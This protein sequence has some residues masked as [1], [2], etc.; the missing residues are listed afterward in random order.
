M[1]AFRWLSADGWSSAQ[2]TGLVVQDGVLTLAPGPAPG[3]GSGSGGF[4]RR[5]IA[6]LPAGFPARRRWT[7]PRHHRLAQRSSYGSPTP[8]SGGCWLR[9]WLLVADSGRCAQRSRTG[10]RR[11]RP[12]DR[13]HRGRAL[14][15]RSGRGPRRPGALLE[16][17]PLWVAVELGG[18]GTAHAAG[19]RTTGGDRRRRAG[20]RAAGRLPPHHCPGV[21]TGTRP[22]GAAGTGAAPARAVDDGDGVLGRYLGLLGA[23]LR[24]TASILG[25]LPGML[26]PAVAPDRADSPWLTRLATWVALDPALLPA[27]EAARRETVFTAA[28]RHGWRG[29]RRGSDRSGPARDRAH[30]GDRRAAG[31]RQWCGGWTARPAPARLGSPPDWSAPTPGRRCW[32]GPHGSAPA[33]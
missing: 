13:A 3:S 15:S 1:S 27:G 28:A 7:A 33:C 12:R 9:I 26:S 20:D 23:Q 29:T 21:A 16:D 24:Q 11:R 31:N 30:R 22:P 4:T 10:H 19:G 18:T 2:L 5:G 32:T 14:A 6:V 17:G 8:P 25:E